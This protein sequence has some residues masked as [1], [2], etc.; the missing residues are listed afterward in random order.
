MASNL[1]NYSLPILLGMH[2]EY[3]IHSPS[4]PSF[5]KFDFPLYSFYPDK[6]KYLGIS[7]ITGSLHNT[8]TFIRFSFKINV[9][10]EPPFLIEKLSN[11]VVSINT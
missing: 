4:L 3:V 8:Y 6:K 5:V 1:A 7:V 9:Y 11:Q 2:D 10:N